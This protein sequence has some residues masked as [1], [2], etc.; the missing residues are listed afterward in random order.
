VAICI[1]YHEDTAVKNGFYK[2]K[3]IKKQRYY[4][5]IPKFLRKKI[6]VYCN[7]FIGYKE[8]I[9]RFFIDCGF[10]NKKGNL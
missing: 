9:P 5:K 6:K 4:C 8:L 7:K 10:I 3:E 2:N 1:L